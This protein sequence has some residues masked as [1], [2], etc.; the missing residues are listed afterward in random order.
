MLTL[1]PGIQER[2]SVNNKGR[3]H[4]SNFRNLMSLIS[5]LLVAQKLAIRQ[6]ILLPLTAPSLTHLVHNLIMV[7]H[8][9]TFHR[10]PHRH[11]PIQPLLGPCSLENP[12]SLPWCP[13]A[14]GRVKDQLR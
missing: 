10:G 9:E 3:R 2:K 12:I 11:P 14:R 1:E 6:L 5:L 4:R 8:R 7:P 13:D